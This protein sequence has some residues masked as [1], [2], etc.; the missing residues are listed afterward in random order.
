MTL[1]CEFLLWVWKEYVE[2][3]RGTW[4]SKLLGV[5]RQGQSDETMRLTV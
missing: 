4:V 5:V 2:T 3:S 1:I